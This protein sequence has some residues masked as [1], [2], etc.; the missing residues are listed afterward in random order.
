[1]VGTTQEEPGFVYQ[2]RLPSRRAKE[3]LSPLAYR[4]LFALDQFPCDLLFVHRDAEKENQPLVKRTE[5]IEEA[6]VLLADKCDFKVTI[7]VIP[8]RM[9]EAWLLIDENAIRVA[10]SNPNGKMRLDLP[11]IRGIENLPDPKETLKSLLKAA[12]G[13]NARRYR[14]PPTHILASCIS[15]F[16]QLRNLTS[17]MEM[18]K[19]IIYGLA[20]LQ[21]NGRT[22]ILT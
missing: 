12:S 15:D 16:S 10:V 4:I 3:S 17:F 21:M 22:L 7:P 1:M 18:E 2:G 19:S 9:T 13:T 6:K 8:I 20:E 5:E 14:E 11:P